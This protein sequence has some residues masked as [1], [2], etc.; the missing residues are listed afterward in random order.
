MPPR[1][2]PRSGRAAGR[3]GR[4]RR[5]HAAPAATRCA[6][7]RP[8]GRRGPRC[9]AAGRRGRRRRPWPPIRTTTAQRAT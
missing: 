1:G 6:A 7:P 9:T 8:G 2:R 4:A 5:R 3:D